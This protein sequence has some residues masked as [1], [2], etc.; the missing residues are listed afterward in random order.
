MLA[1]RMPGVRYGADVSVPAFVMSVSSVCTRALERPRCSVISFVVACPLLPLRRMNAGAWLVRS[2]L[3]SRPVAG[4]G[5]VTPAVAAGRPTAR[6]LAAV[7]FAPATGLPAARRV[8]AF[9]L[10]DLRAA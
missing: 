10:A 6:L 1:P 5:V 8:D 3:V 9:E 2:S 7:V 4:R